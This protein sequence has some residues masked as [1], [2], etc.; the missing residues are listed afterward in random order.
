MSAEIVRIPFARQSRLVTTGEEARVIQFC[1]KT[2]RLREDRHFSRIAGLWTVGVL[3]SVQVAMT[4]VD[5]DDS[6]ESAWLFNLTLTVRVFR[7]WRTY[8][9][10]QIADWDPRSVIL[11][12]SKIN[13]APADDLFARFPADAVLVESNGFQALFSKTGRIALA[14]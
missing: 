5:T 8:R 6:V 2:R 7:E 1:E 11:T 9:V 12:L 3:S 10:S 14:P 4:H 13:K